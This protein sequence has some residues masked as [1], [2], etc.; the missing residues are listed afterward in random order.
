MKNFIALL[1]LFLLSEL[2]GFAQVGINTDNTQP[3]ASAMLDVKSTSKGFLPPRVALTAINSPLPVTA[4][5]NGLL[6]YNTTTAGSPPNNVMEGFYYW[7]GTKWI[8]IAEPQGTN[9]GDML[10]WNGTQWMGVPV[11]LPGQF[12]QLAQSNI[13]TWSGA[14]YPSLTTTTPSSIASTTVT[15]GGNVTSDGGATVSSRGVCWSSS[16]NPTISNSFTTNGSGTG[17]FV[18]NL[19]GLTP[20]T[21]Y[22]LRAWATNNVG[23]SYGNQVSFTTVLTLATVTTAS[24]NPLSAT[25]AISGGNVTE[26]GGSP[27]T[28]RGV[29][30][31]TSSDP[32]ILNSHT[33][34][35]AGTGSF[36]SNITGLAQGTLYFVRAYATNSLGTSYGIN[37]YFTTYT[38]PTVF[39]NAATNIYQTTAVS[40]GSV[41]SDGGS[42]VTQR[43]VCWNTSPN[44]TTANSKTL[45]GVGTGSFV[46]NL[47]GLTPNT[48]YYVRA[49][50]T[51]S[52][53]TA[54]G[55]EVFFTTLAPPTCGSSIIVNHVA[56]TVAPV[57]KTVTYGI[58]T[59]IP[60]EPYKCWITSN[61]G[62]SHQATAVNDATEPSAGWYWQFNLPQGYKHDGAT[63]TPNS[64]WINLINEYSDWLALNDPC[65]L[66]LGG[67]WRI[68]TNTEWTNVDAGTSG[69]WTNWNGPWNS[70][71]KLH[72]AG[73]LYDY[74]GMLID[75]G[76]DGFYWSSS[77]NAYSLGFDLHF[78]SLYCGS[79]SRP[80]A[81]ALPLRCIRE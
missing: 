15:S 53:G 3:D 55:N 51:N 43:G 38:I 68:P 35:G 74:T 5:A 19:T 33:T 28:A 17:V 58:V 24:T 73:D 8:S 71:L 6:V 30:W 27:V 54:Y 66:S 32:T 25:S 34:D 80:K 29:C 11:G 65:T 14:S 12:L 79:E 13:P 1:T 63:R 45:D 26:D 20:Q 42:Y 18:S 72:A 48:L 7:N 46:S 50:A 2:S 21:L 59:N 44:P 62:A 41:N 10:Y 4:P 69:G 36:V 67:S 52:V 76:Y 22:Y 31:S 70:A 40:G 61:L 75:I 47:S 9:M 23:T 49:Y 56:G 77:T 16:P 60:G 64:A 57:T 39:T 37:I 81:T 78:N